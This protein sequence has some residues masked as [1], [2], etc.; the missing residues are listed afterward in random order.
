VQGIVYGR[1]LRFL[2]RPINERMKVE[3]TGEDSRDG[4]EDRTKIRCLDGSCG[5]PQSSGSSIY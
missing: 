3:I 2:Q 5:E 1:S 4:A